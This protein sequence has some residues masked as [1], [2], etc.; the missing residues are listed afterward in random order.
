MIPL[1]PAKI[2]QKMIV[3][4]MILLIVL[5]VVIVLIVLTI[6]RMTLIDHL[7]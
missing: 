2:Q 3:V 5:I 4:L 7:I 1:Y 6:K